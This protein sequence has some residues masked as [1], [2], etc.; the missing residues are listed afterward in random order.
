[1]LH[2]TGADGGTP[3]QIGKLIYKKVAVSVSARE[4][5]ISNEIILKR[6]G[7]RCRIFEGR[8]MVN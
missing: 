5:V 8:I 6:V 3:V 1:M 7:M 2:D 4:T